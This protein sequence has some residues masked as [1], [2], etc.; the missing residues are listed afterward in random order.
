MLEILWKFLR[1]SV[2]WIFLLF[3]LVLYQNSLL[4]IQISTNYQKLNGKST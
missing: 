4:G 2:K 3:P 1:K